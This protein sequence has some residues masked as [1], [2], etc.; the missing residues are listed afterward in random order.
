V[1]ALRH[2]D[3]VASSVLLWRNLSSHVIVGGSMSLESLERPSKRSVS[4]LSK[5]ID[6]FRDNASQYVAHPV[7]RDWKTRIRS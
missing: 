7:R 3:N 5:S 1:K 6:C 2:R 4:S